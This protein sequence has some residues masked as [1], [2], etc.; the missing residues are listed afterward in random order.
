[1]NTDFPVYVGNHS[2]YTY[3]EYVV[4]HSGWLTYRRLGIKT[5]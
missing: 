4:P 3:L 5:D 1:M 2:D